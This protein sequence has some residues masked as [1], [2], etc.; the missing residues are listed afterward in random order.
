[1]YSDIWRN[2]IRIPLGLN[3]RIPNHAHNIRT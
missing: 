2:A 1:M 3:R